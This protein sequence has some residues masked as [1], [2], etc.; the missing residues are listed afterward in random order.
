MQVVLFLHILCVFV[1]LGSVLVESLAESN[2]TLRFLLSLLQGRF[3]LV[4]ALP[5]F[6][7]A[8]LTGGFLAS[9]EPLTPFQA[10]R[11]AAGLIAIGVNIYGLLLAGDRPVAAASGRFKASLRV[12]SSA[13]VSLA[14]ALTIGFHLLAQL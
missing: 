8:L 5:A 13:V 4:V 3:D 11:T 9:H 12:N 10:L 7:G 1:W 6:L 2:P 14:M